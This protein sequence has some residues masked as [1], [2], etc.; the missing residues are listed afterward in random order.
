MGEEPNLGPG[1]SGDV[2]VPIHLSSTFAR[3]RVTEPT[4]GFEY[5]RTSNPT[6][7][8]LEEKLA[9]LEGARHG[10]AFSSG[11][12]AETTL[13]LSLLEKGDHV[14]ASDDLYGGTRR[15]FSQTLAKFGIEFS[16]VDAR[17]PSL[18]SAAVRGN[19][20]MIWLESPTNP[21]MRLCDI[22]EIARVAKQRSVVTVVDNTFAS[23]CFQSPLGL[24]TDVVVHSSTKYLSGHSDVVGGA[25]MLSD[26]RLFERVKFNQNAAGA[27][28]SPF[29]CFLIAR[30]I[31]TLSLRME[32]HASNAQRIA[33]FLSNHKK[34]DG[35]NYPGLK[36]FPQHTLA[37][38]QMSGFGGML[39]FQL[40]GDASAARKVLERTKVFSLAESLGGVESLIEHPATMT[41]A[42][43]PPDQ[44]A[45]LG[46]TDTL[47]RISAGIEDPDD[48]LADLRQ[49]LS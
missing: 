44:R 4:G 9:S 10:L 41:H 35:V 23:P 34:V 18:V 49:A 2:A 33:E 21:L 40:K 32:R 6:R 28:P 22:N 26:E 47:I 38:R 13:C 39:S 48:L 7:R 1:G 46:I 15:L 14:I 36:D 30:G 8:A 20:R 45:K 31:K 12:A 17:R 37:R 42:S 16:F 19:T 3:R 25:L 43:V 29:D 11:M 5:S 24:G 27:V